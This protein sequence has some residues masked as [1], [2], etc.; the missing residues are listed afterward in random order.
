M[1][2]SFKLFFPIKVGAEVVWLDHWLA[3]KGFC[4]VRVLNFAIHFQIKSY[5][6]KDD[7][8]SHT[9]TLLVCTRCHIK[10]AL[11]GIGSVRSPFYRQSASDPNQTG[12]VDWGKACVIGFAVRK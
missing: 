4:H 1:K 8:L 12:T 5:F 6:I 7:I 2:N 10:V 9:S 3:L 11:P